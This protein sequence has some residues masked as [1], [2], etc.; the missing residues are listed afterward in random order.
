MTNDKEVIYAAL[1][2]RLS[3]SL[4]GCVTKSRTVRHY[5]EV[6][7][8]EQPAFFLEQTNVE[9]SGD[10]QKPNKEVI[11]ANALIYV[12]TEDAPGPMPTINN[13]VT[14]ASLGLA[15]QPGEASPSYTTTLGGLVSSVR[16]K[17]IEY[18]GGNVGKQG[19][20]IVSIEVLTA[21]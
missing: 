8:P 14:S 3:S 19:V 13:L 5:E 15:R 17:N 12:H 2:A 6:P 18:G 1:Y 7:I 9:Y 16:V 10:M 11:R 21:L 4:A 20:A